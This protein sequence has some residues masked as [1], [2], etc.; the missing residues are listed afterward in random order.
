M[1]TKTGDTRRTITVLWLCF[2]ASP[3]LYVVVGLLAMPNFDPRVPAEAAPM[4][5]GGAFL[6]GLT[7]LASGFMLPRLTINEEKLRARGSRGAASAL[8]VQISMISF[9]LLESAAVLGLFSALLT[10]SLADLFVGGLVTAFAVV[11]QRPV[12]QAH[13]ETIERLYPLG[14]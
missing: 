3:L 7:T 1:A 13:L 6:V 9:G 10:R 5:R 11:L 2:V 4:I 8:L 12:I 14:A